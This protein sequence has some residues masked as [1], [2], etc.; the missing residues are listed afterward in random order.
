MRAI[1]AAL[2]SIVLA[3]CGSSPTAPTPP[4]VV[5]A[6][7]TP[8]PTPTTPAP[9]TVAGRVIATNGRHAINNAR[10]ELMGQTVIT[11]SHGRFAFTLSPNTTT[12]AVNVSAAD[13]ETLRAT[14]SAST[15]SPTLEVI[16][17]GG[18]FDQAF[19]RQ[20]VFDATNGLTVLRRQAQAPHIYVR[21]VDNSGAP[22][23]SLT[24]DTTAAAISNVAGQ[25]TGG[26]FGIAGLER[27][28][29]TR[30]GQPGWITVEWSRDTSTGQ[31][32][33]T[34]VFS[35]DLVT[36]FYLNRL[37]ACGG[38][39]MRP[40][41]VKHEIGHAMGFYHTDNPTDLMYPASGACDRNPSAREMYHAAI[42]YSR[43]INTA[44]PDSWPATAVISAVG[45][46]G[47]LHNL[48]IHPTRQ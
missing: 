17:H 12:Y 7:P 42:A 29:G 37:C 27:G 18:G 33:R 38:S 3:G 46:T 32:G 24:L 13:I 30:I 4:S 5:I 8:P 43:P 15:T 20:F 25:L 28:A 47:G 14:V 48:L 31:C 11:D 16:A 45:T 21:T 36:L 1:A 6:P 40:G 41:T 44:V 23:D 2:M 9:S 10:V 34:G 35:G 19:Y 26:R 39:S 22:I